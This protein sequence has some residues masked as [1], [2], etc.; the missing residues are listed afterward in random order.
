[1][2]NIKKYENVLVVGPF[3][4]DTKTKIISKGEENSFAFK[5]FGK[6]FPIELNKKNSP[7]IIEIVPPGN[8]NL[9]LV[10]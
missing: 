7:Y 8:F 2:I 5:I 9:I 4:P 6:D 1:M 10:F 3:F